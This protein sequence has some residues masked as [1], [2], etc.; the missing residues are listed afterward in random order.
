MQIHKQGC[1]G[2]FSD[3]CSSEVSVDCAL[4]SC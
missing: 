4:G 2:K 1:S 3:Y